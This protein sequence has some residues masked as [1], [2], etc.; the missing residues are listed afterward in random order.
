MADLLVELAG[1]V[2]VRTSAGRELRVASRKGLALLAC[3]ALKPGTTHSRDFL[4]GLLWED[5][6]PELARSSLRQ[7]LA[8][9]RRSFGEE[10]ATALRA[11]AVSVSLDA[12]VATSDVAQ[13]QALLRE[14]TPGALIEAAGRCSGELFEGLDARSPAF[15]RWMEEHRRSFRRQVLEAM[16]RAAA[17][18]DAAGDLAGRVAA[19]ERLTSLEPANERAQRELMEALARQ[20]RYTEAL[21]Q[22]RLCRD[23]LRRDLDVAT[24]PATDALHREILRRRRAEDPGETSRDDEETPAVAAAS[25]VAATLREA[26]VMVVRIGGPTH[27]GSEDPEL[28]RQRWSRAEARVRAAVERQGGSADRPSQGEIVAAFGLVTLTGNEPDR[29]A[30][31]ALDLA[32][33]ASK[34]GSEASL[35]VGIAGGQVL[36][37]AGDV[38]FP[39]A[40]SPVGRARELSH[41]CPFGCVTVSEDVAHRLSHRYRLEPARGEGPGEAWRIT[42]A[43]AG[44]S[45]E[46]GRRFAGRR[47]ELAMLTAMFE[48]VR[49]SGRGRVVVVRGDAGIG[50]S[51]VLEALARSAADRGAT[52]HVLQVLDFGQSA[53]ERPVPALASR[54]LGLA[55]TASS[56][57]RAA[58]VDAAVSAGRLPADLRLLA[59]D[60][61]GAAP[62]SEGLARLAAMNSGTRERER[63]HVLHQLVLQGTTEPLLIL[64]EDVHWADPLE[65]AQ[66]GDLAAAAAVRP[67]LLALSTRPEGDPTN[68]AWRAR[69]RGCPVTALDLAPLDDDEAR[70]LAAG[71]SDLPAEVLERCLATAAGHPLFLEQLLR[72]ARAGQTALPGSV[73]GL[74]T[75]RIERLPAAS[76]HA[77]HAAAV[78]GVRFTLGALRHLLAD[79]SYDAAPLESA[80]LLAIE[81]EDCRYAHA[82]IRDAVYESLLSSTRRELHK[83]AAVWFESRDSGLH[84]DHLAAAADPR[85]P[86]AYLRAA[87]EAMRAYRLDRARVHAERARETARQAGDLFDACATLGDVHLAMGRADEAVA[88][89][90]ECID[91][92]TSAA[93]RARAWLGLATGLRIVDRYDEAL[94]ALAHA[95]RAMG[96]SDLRGLAQ[97][98]TLRGNLHFPRGELDDCLDAHQRALEF[99]RRAGS[100]E[101]VARAL[102]G[103]GD[104]HFQRGWMRTAHDEFRQC[105]E[106]A[107]QQGFAG[108]RIKY[109]PMLAATRAYVGQFELGVDAATKAA[110]AARE[111]GD[112][113]AELLAMLVEAS[114]DLNCARFEAACSRSERSLRLARDMGAR[115]FEAEGLVLEG[116]SRLGM[117]DRPAAREWLEQAVDLARAVAPTYCGP[118]ALAALAR[119]DGDP[120]RSRALLAEGEEWLARGCVGHNYLEFHFHGIEFSLDHGDPEAARRYADELAAYTREEPLPW[121]D[122]VIARGRALARVLGGERGDD[123]RQALDDALRSAREM[124]FAALLP[125]LEEAN[126]THFS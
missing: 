68:A 105:I 55:P 118:L 60:L 125:G 43:Q 16:E 94:A 96:T 75:A 33:E 12:D 65:M 57:E 115:R 97:L 25:P 52:V 90:R 110:A 123:V 126:R 19:L 79:S 24:E 86:A 93:A 101:D 98:W 81:G 13:F 99:S 26:I 117:G 7:A 40:G 8:A 112:L 4:A 76:Q 46:S 108:L 121:A 77:V 92:A 109:L 17:Q 3:L 100:P 102:G 66:L 20:G 107:E 39:L 23:A 78:L 5:S 32:S 1:G 120:A 103:L 74:V 67:V 15:D 37:A 50:K 91:L 2:R 58:A 122:A 71:Y 29:A 18:C 95:E 104:A 30:R 14:G 22:Y 34:P 69:A 64:V 72:A 62:T 9:L 89:F 56:V 106:L 27:P 114:I 47:A 6:D 45:T 63:A 35:A 73:R 44:T 111:V 80:G 38:P 51:A 36:P 61:I 113:R 119:A 11:D 83:R 84:A 88:A 53:E 41:S 21:R 59:Y 70:E 124:Q 28:T 49:A 87:G 48:R 42:P 10:F 116:L 85:A 31:A 54:L 82:L